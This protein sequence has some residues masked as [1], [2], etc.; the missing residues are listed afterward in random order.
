MAIETCSLRVGDVI[1][2][3]AEG[4]APEAEYVLFDDADVELSMVPG[5]GLQETSYRT[6]VGAARERLITAGVTPRLALESAR[7]MRRDLAARYARGP[8]AWKVAEHLGAAELFEGQTFNGKTRRYRGRWLDLESL[9]VD[10]RLLRA[11]TALQALHLVALLE[12]CADGIPIVLTTG[13]IARGLP[14]GERTYR[15]PDVSHAVEVPAALEKLHKNPFPRTATRDQGRSADHLLDVIRRK[16]SLAGSPAAQ[17][18]L[19]KVERAI[20][21]RDRPTSGPLA[22]PGLWGLETR[23]ALGDHADVVTDVHAIEQTSGRTIG[24]SY[25]R[26]FAALVGGTMEPRALAANVSSLASAGHAFPELSLLAAR[27]WAAAGDPTRALA[28]ARDVTNDA[29]AAPELKALA[30]ELAA[31]M[32]AN[33]PVHFAAYAPPTLVGSIPPPAIDALP[34]SHPPDTAIEPMPVVSITPPP[35]YG[36]PYDPL[37]SVRVEMSRV[38]ARDPRS[39]PPDTPPPPSE[40]PVS[41]LPPSGPASSRGSMRPQA[42]ALDLGTPSSAYEWVRRKNTP[43]PARARTVKDFEAVEVPP[44]PKYQPMHTPPPPAA[45]ASQPPPRASQPPP[46]AATRVSVIAREPARRSHAAVPVPP[47]AETT[48]SM[49]DSAAPDSM[50]DE[51]TVALVRRAPQGHGRPN[52]RAGQRPAF[53]VEKA[54]PPPG[55]PELM[56]PRQLDTG[57]TEFVDTLTLPPPGLPGQPPPL[58]FIPGSEVEARVAFTCFARDL[59]REFRL[60][61]GVTCKTDVATVEVLQRSLRELFPT[62]EVV[63]RQGVIEVRRHA[64]LLS[65]LLVRVMGGYWIDIF[66]SDLADWAMYVPPATR[67]WPFARVMRYVVMGNQETDLVSYYLE[68]EARALRA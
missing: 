13:E 12:E 50:D 59:A 44:K 18:R 33:R 40:P 41:I 45:R 22:T 46:I 29:N 34:E 1:V 47:V 5:K 35:G 43:I 51:R 31:D 17:A 4:G 15:R 9:A 63:D 37:P 52:E 65:E 42:P 24:T 66:S 8:V 10:A 3:R 14:P 58:D 38:S 26:A 53:G 2:L 36:A 62:G 64:A 19:L 55:S 30:R 28:Y 56:Q 67:V 39:E 25:I 57:R 21:M 68:L 54:P 60:R 49:P 6:T 7:R 27:A 16:M 61:Y 11:T 20:A 48:P 23:L 32:T